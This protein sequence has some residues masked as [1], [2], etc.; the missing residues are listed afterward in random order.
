VTVISLSKTFA[1]CT[2]PAEPGSAPRLIDGMTAITARKRMV[3]RLIDE[4]L[5]GSTLL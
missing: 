1:S 3:A 5:S 4:P 2:V